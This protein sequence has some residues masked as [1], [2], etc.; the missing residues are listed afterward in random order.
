VIAEL[1]ELILERFPHSSRLVTSPQPTAIPGE[2]LMN[3][4]G[5]SAAGCRDQPVKAALAT[6]SR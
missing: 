5:L 3:A 6:C 4:G 2:R 1:T